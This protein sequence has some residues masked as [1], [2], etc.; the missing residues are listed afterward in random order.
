ML[1]QLADNITTSKVF[2]AA[3]TSTGNKAALE[4]YNL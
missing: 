3:N 1:K 2:V 4:K